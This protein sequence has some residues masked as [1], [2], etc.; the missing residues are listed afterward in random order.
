LSKSQHCALSSSEWKV[1]IFG[2]IIQPPAH[3]TAIPITQ[4]THCS[5]I[6]FQAIGNERLGLSMTFQRLLQE[7]QG[8]SFIPF[9]RAVFDRYESVGDSFR[10]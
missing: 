8:R 9:P 1:A 7:C 5:R 6:G 4:V 10:V 3:L 2:S